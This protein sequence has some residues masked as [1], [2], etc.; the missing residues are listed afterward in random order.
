MILVSVWSAKGGGRVSRDRKLETMGNK[1]NL[2]L[3]AMPV[4][5]YRTLVSCDS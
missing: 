2:L 5:T 3:L 4:L 1:R